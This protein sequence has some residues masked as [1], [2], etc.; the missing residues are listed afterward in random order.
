MEKKAPRGVRRSRGDGTKGVWVRA[1]EGPKS[2]PGGGMKEMMALCEG[3]GRDPFAKDE[4]A[5]VEAA[6][7]GGKTVPRTVEERRVVNKAVDSGDRWG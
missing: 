4:V 7:L 6:C 5:A 3:G 1:D 2:P